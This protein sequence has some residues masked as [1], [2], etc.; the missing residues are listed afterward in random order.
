MLSKQA[1]LGITATNYKFVTIG[2]LITDPTPQPPTSMATVNDAAISWYSGNT[3]FGAN[4]NPRLPTY[5]FDIENIVIN[6]MY[7]HSDEKTTC[8]NCTSI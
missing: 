7:H 8:K 2:L 6:A 4:M 5:P 3:T 1:Y